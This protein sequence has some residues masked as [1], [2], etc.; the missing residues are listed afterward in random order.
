MV[1]G[2]NPGPGEDL[3]DSLKFHLPWTRDFFDLVSGGG[4]DA[5]VSQQSLKP[6]SGDRSFGPEGLQLVSIFV[7]ILTLFVTQGRVLLVV[8]V[9]IVDV[10]ILLLLLLSRCALGCWALRYH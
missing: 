10:I 9:F 5:Q 7:H 6:A 4:G 3:Y 2:N 1:P 8:F